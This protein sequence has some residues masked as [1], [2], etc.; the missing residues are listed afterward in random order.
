MKKC[1]LPND[2]LTILSV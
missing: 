1:K 2:A